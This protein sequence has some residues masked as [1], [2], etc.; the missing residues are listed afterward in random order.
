MS[1]IKRLKELYKLLRDVDKKMLVIRDKA[2]DDKML[3]DAMEVCGLANTSIV[4]FVGDL[5]KDRED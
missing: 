5:I 3:A 2:T 4:S 1:D